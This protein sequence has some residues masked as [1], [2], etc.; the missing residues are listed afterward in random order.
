M[1][2]VFSSIKMIQITFRIFAS[3]SGSKSTVDVRCRCCIQWKWWATRGNSNHYINCRI[4]RIRWQVN[5]PSEKNDM[6]FLPLSLNAMR[7]HSLS[8]VLTSYHSRQISLSQTFSTQFQI[9]TP[10]ENIWIYKN[11]S[12]SHCSKTNEANHLKLTWKGD[13]CITMRKA[14]RIQY[15]NVQTLYISIAWMGRWLKLKYSSQY[16]NMYETKG[17]SFYTFEHILY[18]KCEGRCNVRFHR[19]INL[20]M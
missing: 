15:S 20:L 8:T 17:Y 14:H 13:F 16:R 7:Y 11:K 1:F 4:Y 19:N 3:F 2:F 9:F 10:A 5:T 6:N 12:F 18:N